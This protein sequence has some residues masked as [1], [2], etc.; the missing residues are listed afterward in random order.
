MKVCF[1]GLGS[2]GK[3]HLKNILEIAEAFHLDVE[4][5][6]LRRT[7]RIPEEELNRIVT[8][9]ADNA[10]QLDRD[11]DIVFITNPTSLHYATIQLMAQRTQHMFIEK[12]IFDAGSYLISDLNLNP[13]GIYYV[14]GPLRFSE[15]IQ[16]FKEII[17]KENVY[18]ARAIC[19]S[20]LPDW[21]QETDYRLTYSADKTKG[22]G[23]SLD[24][25]HEWDY[26]NLLFGLP[27]KVHRI[28]G[29]YSHLE[30][31]SEDTA[32]YIADYGDKMVELHLDYYG[33]P[34]RRQIELLT[35]KGLISGNL[36]DGT[37]SF[38]DG[39][40]QICFLEN[41]NTIYLRE[42]KFFIEHI[43]ENR[44]LNNMEECY[45]VLKTALGEEIQ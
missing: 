35:E 12:P 5:H 29:K 8:M 10:E 11:Y 19:S 25:I 22:G 16:S 23:V 13:D 17:K 32:V 42:M 15:V 45:S 40:E 41:K 30:I 34:A 7:G 2:I 26:I 3:R 18:C 33:K 21:R 6:A 1:C 9:A 39:R 20:Y 27:K 24:L 37:I 44:P 28:G 14:A 38:A 43:L 4:V 36:L 31:N